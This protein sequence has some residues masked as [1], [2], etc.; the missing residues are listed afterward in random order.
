MDCTGGDVRPIVLRTPPGK[1][2]Y[3]QWYATYKVLPDEGQMV[4]FIMPRGNS[5]EGV[6]RNGVFKDREG[7]PF[8]NIGIW[9]PL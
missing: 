5:I 6:Y 4:A 2:E 1:G 8:P 3:L 9:R 7:N